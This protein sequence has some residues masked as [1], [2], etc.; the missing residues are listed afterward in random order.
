MSVEF[1]MANQFLRDLSDNT[2]R[3]MRHKVSE[4]W[5]PHKPPIGYLNNI[6]L[7]GSKQYLDPAK[8]PLFKDPA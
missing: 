5:M 2:K 1:G 6:K 7:K 3:G 8:P 4:G